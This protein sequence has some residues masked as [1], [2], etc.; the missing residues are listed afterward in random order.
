MVLRAFNHTRSS[1]LRRFDF[2]RCL[3]RSASA[4]DHRRVGIAE[5]RHPVESDV[6]HHGEELAEVLVDE[7]I[8]PT[9][10]RLGH[11]HHVVGV[12]PEGVQSPAF[13]LAVQIYPESLRTT[14][15]NRGYYG[16]LQH[17]AK[18]V[19]TYYFGWYDGNPANLNP[20]PPVASGKRYVSYMG[21]AEALLVRAQASF[22][23]G[24]YRWV[25]E[26]LN[27]LVFAAPENE[28]AKD[29]LASAYDQL[30]YQSESGP[31]RDVY[32]TAALELRQGAPKG[33]AGAGN[34]G[35]MMAHIPIPK[36]FDA[37]CVRLDGPKADGKQL[38][39]NITFT[40]RQ[41]TY[42]L[43]LE[44]AVLHHKRSAPDPEASATLDLTYELF[45]GIFTGQVDMAEAAAAGKLEL[46]GN[47]EDL[48]QLFS[49]LTRPQGFFNIVTP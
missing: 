12:N 14:F 11:E 4:G 45:L 40:D 5:V 28:D 41:E 1:G 39:V 25:A 30:G 20:L 3:A 44:N 18:A 19:Y 26:V 27:H 31:W 43:R 36:F 33:V 6:R 10:H 38:S 2:M 48:I 13:G 29:L 34:A 21:G 17:N 35:N 37:M 46:D 42:V 8:H 22:D 7:L 49:L 32:L 16:T 23:E 24:D 15:A 47:L 9:D